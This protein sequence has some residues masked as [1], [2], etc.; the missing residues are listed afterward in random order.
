MTQEEKDKSF[1]NRI[2]DDKEH[3]KDVIE[4]YYGNEK[5]VLS[6][7]ETVTDVFLRKTTINVSQLF[8]EHFGQN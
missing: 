6:G 4:E 5:T 2:K 8:R 3:P 1:L 7:K